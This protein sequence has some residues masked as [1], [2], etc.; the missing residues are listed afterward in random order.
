[1]LGVSSRS[2]YISSCTANAGRPILARCE[3]CLTELPGLRVGVI[4]AGRAAVAHMTALSN[5]PWTYLVGLHDLPGSPGTDAAARFGCRNFVSFDALLSA[6]DAVIIATPN[7]THSVLACEALRLRR[8]VLCEKPMATSVTDAERM[9]EHAASAGQVASV[10]FNYRYLPAVRTAV[11]A[12]RAGVIGEMVSVRLSLCRRS[13]ST[14]NPA[15][16]RQSPEQGLTGG[17][18]GDLGV[19]LFDLLRA[20]SGKEIVID[21][22]GATV[23]SAGAA[24]NG[25]ASAD[26]FA[27]V[28]GRLEGGAEFVAVASKIARRATFSMRISGS[29][30]RI[31]YRSTNAELRILKMNGEVADFRMPESATSAPVAGEIHGWEHS[32]EMQLREWSLQVTGSATPRT[33]AT[34]NDGLA[35]QR[36]LGWINSRSVVT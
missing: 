27:A 8:A 35:A 15:A 9:V 14:H 34:F 13:G 10:G 22:C 20:I 1:M 31:E 19:H 6:A 17:A 4:G 26:T 24:G 32:F 7:N 16:W 11:S 30:G 21:S 18:T 29:T 28:E 23:R 5:I 12:I 36:V 3:V 25:R 33:L 2:E